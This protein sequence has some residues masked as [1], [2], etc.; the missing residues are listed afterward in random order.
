V[1]QLS[2]LGV[3]AFMSGHNDLIL[4]F[5]GYLLAA[6]FL[7]LGYFLR[8][9]NRRFLASALVA[10]GTIVALEK[11]PGSLWAL[12]P[13]FTFRD[14]RGIEHRVRS[15][16]G[17]YPPSHQVDDLVDVFYDPHAPQEAIID[18]KAEIQIARICFLVGVVAAIIMTI[19]AI[20][21]RSDS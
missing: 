19:I 5:A 3:I 21:V 20:F 1:A 12:F 17:R 16:T 7:F 6:L 11:M 9:K 15:T 10:K 18:P 2:T 8:S 14:V 4:A 13:V